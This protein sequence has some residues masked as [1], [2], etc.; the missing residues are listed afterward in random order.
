MVDI[1]DEDNQLLKWETE[2]YFTSAQ[3]RLAKIRT[4]EERVAGLKGKN[5]KYN[6]DLSVSDTFQF[7]IGVS[8]IFGNLI[9]FGP[10]FP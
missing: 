5:D 3:T 1:D 8:L 10:L 6:G 4:A 2:F 7:S 9:L